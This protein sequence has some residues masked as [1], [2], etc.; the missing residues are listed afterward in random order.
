[1]GLGESSRAE[2]WVIVLG[3]LALAAWVVLQAL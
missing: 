3:L 1:M 2:P